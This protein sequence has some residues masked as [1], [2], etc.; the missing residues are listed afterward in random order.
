MLA[1]SVVALVLSVASLVLATVALLRSGGREQIAALVDD[2]NRRARLGYEEALDRIERAQ[3][4]LLE[5]KTQTSA[6][7]RERID[8]LS[9]QLAEVKTKAQ[10]GLG[11]LNT[12]VSGRARVAQ[13]DLQRRLRL[14]EG[15]LEVLF[16]RAEMVRAEHLAQRGDFVDAEV[17]LEDAVAKVREVRLRSPSEAER[18]LRFSEV[19]EALNNAIRSVRMKAEDYRSRINRVVS[20]S[21][22][23]LGS[24]ESREQRLM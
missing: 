21:D 15:S 8:A 11:N 20:A 14:L 19:V 10:A 22:V 4:R 17:L 2:L 3:K 7:L 16:A 13:E 9:D 5:V 23:L 24:L 6:E 12:E 1:I 18:E